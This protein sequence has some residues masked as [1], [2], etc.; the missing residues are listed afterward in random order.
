MTTP[1]SERGLSVRVEHHDRAQAL[2]PI[3]I[4]GLVHERSWPFRAVLP[5]PV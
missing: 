3:A 5:W 1:A 4:T 2:L